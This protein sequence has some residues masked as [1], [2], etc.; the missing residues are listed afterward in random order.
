MGT[1]SITKTGTG[2]WRLTGA[3]EYSGT[4]TV[5]GG[6]LTVNGAH[7]GKGAVTVNA[8]ATLAGTGSLAAPVTIKAGASIL[9]GDTLVRGRSALT[10][11]GKLTVQSGGTISIPV[12]VADP[13]AVKTNHL[14]LSGGA[15]LAKANIE[16]DIQDAT[17]ALNL[18]VGTEL[19]IFSP[20]ST[21]TG[22][23]G[24]ITPATPGTDKVWDTTDLLKKG[25]LRV[26]EDPS[27]GIGAVSADN[28]S[29]TA[30]D[31]SGK[32]SNG[33]KAS[34]SIYIYYNKKVVR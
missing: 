18:P 10:L 27:V 24:T 25:I 6:T 21:V 30:Y 32:P 22:T 34:R 19:K 23:F 29:S 5:K 8:G 2:V 11:K 17:S 1:V 20:A 12:S 7:T 26:A 28:P 4:T 33:S 15:S 31:L 13:S 14:V 3:N 16:L 9:S